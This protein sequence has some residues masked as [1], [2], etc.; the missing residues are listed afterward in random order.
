MVR[1]MWSLF[2]VLNRTIEHDQQVKGVKHVTK[3]VSDRLTCLIL[4]CM[5]IC[6]PHADS[7]LFENDARVVARCTA[8]HLMCSIAL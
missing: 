6:S 4:V 1:E 2:V 5:V 8:R 7:L 3:E